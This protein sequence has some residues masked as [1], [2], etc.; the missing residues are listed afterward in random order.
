MTID[1]FALGFSFILMHEM[2]AMRCHEWRILPLTSFMKERTGMRVFIFMH[3]PLFY[4]PL[5][6]QVFG[7]ESFR[8]GASIFFI[9]HFVLHLL[10]LMHQKNE[11]KDWISW[12]IISGV[13]ICGL[14]YLLVH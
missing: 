6:P 13:G 1:F 2:D 7:N 12:S 5:L 10:F 4:I 11:F 14:L 8:F 3:I 9:I